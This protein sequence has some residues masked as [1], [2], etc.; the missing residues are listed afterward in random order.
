[1][2]TIQFKRKTE[3]VYNMD[4][5]IAYE[6]FKIPRIRKMHCDMNA[7]R[8]HAKYGSYANSDMFEGMIARK[9]KELFPSGYIKLSDELPENVKINTSGFLAVVTIEV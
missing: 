2:A 5:S 4:D 8:S 7:F 6:G 3:K 9:M 1:M